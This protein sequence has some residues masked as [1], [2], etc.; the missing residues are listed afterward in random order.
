MDESK[1]R[2]GGH[3][4]P[5]Q[6][7]DPGA[8]SSDPPPDAP[9]LMQ[10]PIIPLTPPVPQTA[11]AAHKA[12]QPS[13]SPPSAGSFLRNIPVP[14]PA[15][16]FQPLPEDTFAPDLG[17]GVLKAGTQL[18]PYQIVENLGKGAVG[19]VYK[20]VHVHLNKTVA[21]KV[22]SPHVMQ[23]D[24]CVARF[25]REMKLVGMLD[26]PNIVRATDAGEV[27]GS[28]YLAMEYVEGTDLQHLVEK[29]GPL[30]VARACET[31]RQAALGLAAAHERCLVHRDIKPSNLFQPS[32][33][34][35][36]KIL[37]LGLARLTETNLGSEGLTSIGQCMGTPDY[38]APEQWDDARNA[39]A[40]SDLYA[41]GCTLFFLLAGRAPYGTEKFPTA[42]SKMIAHMSQPIPDVRSAALS[43]GD[44]IPDGVVAIYRRLMAKKPEERFASANELA[45]ALLPFCTPPRPVAVKP[46]SDPEASALKSSWRKPG[47]SKLSGTQTSIKLEPEF[48]WQFERNR[49]R[50]VRKTVSG[51]ILLTLAIASAFLLLWILLTSF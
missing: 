17:L 29:E 7:P 36:I 4:R 51:L 6:D 8:A 10:A 37:D 34:G 47:V 19:A 42:T 15:A 5:G 45:T 9:T 46:V 30:P 41:L 44:E 38:M 31:I 23:N 49:A 27:D 25:K 24:D 20:A 1:H 22:V 18:G 35:Q 16:P 21:L 39:N 26:H 3:S 28:Y 50:R 11:P 40:P 2:A 43:A 13:G 14:A 48:D 32:Q 33:G 12:A